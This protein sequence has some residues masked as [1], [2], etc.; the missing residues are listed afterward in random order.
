MKR[1]TEV[2]S[3]D[4]I[5]VLVS[6]EHNTR[7]AYHDVMQS[8]RSMGDIDLDATLQE[9]VFDSPALNEMDH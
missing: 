5:E 8:L 9:N 3:F 7:N 2:I 4:G 6:V 1:K